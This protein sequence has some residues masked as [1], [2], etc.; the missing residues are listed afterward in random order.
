MIQTKQSGFPYCFKA[1]SVTWQMKMKPTTVF[2]QV[3]TADF[4]TKLVKRA[5]V[6]VLTGKRRENEAKNF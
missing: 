2:L 1:T 4:V 6:K 5:R 3:C